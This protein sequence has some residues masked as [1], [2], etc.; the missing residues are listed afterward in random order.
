MGKIENMTEIEVSSVSEYIKKICELSGE[1]AP[2]WFRGVKD[3]SYRLIPTLFREKYKYQDEAHMMNIFRARAIPHLKSIPDTDYEW[4]FV[5]QHYGLP[6]RLLDWSEEP[7]PALG[8]ALL[9]KQ[10][11]KRTLEDGREEEY[12][13]DSAVYILNPLEL[14]RKNNLLEDSTHIPNIVTLPDEHDTLFAVS[15]EFKYTIRSNQF[16]IAIIGPL[17][18]ERIVAQKGA[19]TLFPKYSE[20]ENIELDREGD[21]DFLKAKI[22]IPGNVIESM[23]Q[24][25]KYLGVTKG[26]LFP[27]LEE[28]AKQIKSDYTMAG[29]QE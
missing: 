6:T 16:P 17:N 27:S 19:F 25:L 11:K 13:L 26:T 22:I 4:L 5:M 2:L 29:G 10:T 20:L 9:D 18:N 1:D 24:E 21:N 8:F 14:N 23:L 7:I 12:Y 15:S 3:K 28:T